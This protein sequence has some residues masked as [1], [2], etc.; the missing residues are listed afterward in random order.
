M[1]R[2]FCENM[3]RRTFLRVGASSILVLGAGRLLGGVPTARANLR[4][5]ATTDMHGFLTDFDYYRDEVTDQFGFVRA[6]SLIRE[7]Q[8]EVKNFVL[9][10]NG[11]LIQGNPIAD[12]HAARGWKNGDVDPNIFALNAM[13]YDVSTIGNHEFNY[14][15][16]FLDAAI[17]NANF[18]VICSNVIDAN[19]NEPRYR[20]YF[21]QKKMIVDENGNQS[22]VKIGYV[23]FVPPKIMI[24][25]KKHLEG[26]VLALDILKSAEKYVQILKKEGAEVIIALAHSGARNVPYVEG[27]EN[28]AFHV[29]QVKGID[30][31]VF[32]HSHRLF[33][34]NEFADYDNVNITK[35]TASNTPT[36]MAGYW[37]N[38]ISVIDLA[39]SKIDG[40]WKM[41][42][43]TAA[44]RGIYDP[45]TKTALAKNDPE[46]QQILKPIHEKV[47][48]F[49]NE[50]IGASKRDIFSYLAMIQDD[51]AIELV[52]AAQIAY[53]KDL[54]NSVP[55]L[56]NLPVL[57]A[58]APFKAGY[59]KK[60]P[61][62]YTEVPSGNLSYRNAADLY[63]YPNT[64]VVVKVTGE[65][66]REWL[67]MSAVIFNTIDPE[68][69]RPQ[70][71]I[72]HRVPT[73][74]F[75]VID[76]VTYEIDVTSPPRYA[77]KKLANP[78]DHRIINL[79]YK[80][81]P[82]D[83]DDEFLVATNNY[84]GFSGTYP[85]TGADHV[86][87]QAPDENRQILI[88]FIAEESK[89]NGFVPTKIDKNWRIAKIE[90]DTLLD[91]RFETSPK[92]ADFIKNSSIYPM[93]FIK[94]DDQGFDVYKITLT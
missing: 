5:I 22:S 91:V 50:P 56:A 88:N 47:R 14:G 35:G 15:L 39:L 83:P 13:K 10:D 70:V 11:D 7:A 77:Y 25:D 23:G 4:V 68:S 69:R 20:P 57:S 53:V 37:A 71:L 40:K 42:D 8:A 48:A 41:T 93:Q 1:S 89:K 67:E 66:L 45:K 73:Y 32:G 9:V 43:G 52:N 86:V 63:V 65:E 75:D 81:K 94:T 17:S 84:R 85:G 79:R 92:A 76:G 49:M 2:V 31:V 62:H 72:N 87:F 80:N 30:A 51:P 58:M 6:V 60:D 59:G 29:A 54:A 3:D 28:C 82:V 27:M 18:P 44:L 19:T 16:E 21:I 36:S 46:M 33:P 74:N 34:N 38:N 26:K 64:L 78:R 55:E 12:Y 61:T 90:T 24:W